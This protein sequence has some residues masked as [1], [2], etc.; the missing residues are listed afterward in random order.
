MKTFHSRSLTVLGLALIAASAFA[1]SPPADPDPMSKST[2]MQ[3]NQSSSQSTSPYSSTDSSSSSS[4][5]TVSMQTKFDSLDTNRDGYIDKQEAAADPQLAKQF[6]RLDANKDAKLSMTE[7]NNA[8]G[9]ALNKSS[10]SDTSKD[11]DRQR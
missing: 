3:D 11:K 5:L 9:L 2:P 6:E 4:K 10:S 1:A 8:K 7:F